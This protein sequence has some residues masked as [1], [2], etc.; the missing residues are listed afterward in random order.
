ME[1]GYFS[2]T[3][4]WNLLTRQ[5]ALLYISRCEGNGKSDKYFYIHS[6]QR[7]CRV[8]NGPNIILGVGIN[9]IEFT[10]I[11]A[12][13]GVEEVAWQYYVEEPDMTARLNR[14]SGRVLTALLIHK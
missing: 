7:V 6:Y 3:K 10:A 4:D 2:S 5:F 14:D 9:F 8:S 1:S 11:G 12:K 13:T